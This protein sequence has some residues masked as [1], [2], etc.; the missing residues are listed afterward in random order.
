M[1]ADGEASLPFVRDNHF[2]TYQVSESSTRNNRAF[3]PGT[4]Q[5]SDD[6]VSRTGRG[7]DT[8]ARSDLDHGVRGE[9]QGLQTGLHKS[10]V[11]NVRPAQGHPPRTSSLARSRAPAEPNGLPPSPHPPQPRPAG[12]PNTQT[13]STSTVTLSNLDN[14]TGSNRTIDHYE[15]CQRNFKEQFRIQKESFEAQLRSQ[16][17]GH[18][19]RQQVQAD[20]YENRLQEALD[21]R[22]QF[23][24]A[25]DDAERQ[26]R[27][28]IDENQRLKDENI[29]LR[30]K[31]SELESQAQ[32]DNEKYSAELAAS[33]ASV[34]TLKD[35]ERNVDQLEERLRLVE[36][37][38]SVQRESSH[39]LASKLKE[40]NNQLLARSEAC[41]HLE[42]E[43][44]GYKAQTKR[45][46]HLWQNST[47]ELQNSILEFE[48]EMWNLHQRI[49]FLDRYIATFHLHQRLEDQNVQRKYLQQD[50]ELGRLQRMLRVNVRSEIE[51]IRRRGSGLRE[52]IEA[53]ERSRNELQD[54]QEGSEDDD[55]TF[56]DRLE[57]LHA[58]LERLYAEEE[59]VYAKTKQLQTQDQK[60]SS[61]ITRL[62]K[63]A[64]KYIKQIQ[65]PGGTTLTEFEISKKNLRR[66]HCASSAALHQSKS[67]LPELIQYNDIDADELSECHTPDDLGQLYTF[68]GDVGRN[69]VASHLSKKQKRNSSYHSPPKGFF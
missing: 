33:E 66:L 59:Q 30:G 68:H 40:A 32:Q 23:R 17:D 52:S 20:S 14:G 63:N 38:V 15:P 57:K 4:T 51:V 11:D 35:K 27:Y 46:E 6:N 44:Q 29:R 54:Q 24:D 43:R 42:M 12:D 67:S 50:Q 53:T 37:E 65:Q 36:Q 56:F 10:S 39:D 41:N 26:A 7:R 61:D 28:D 60:I 58:D 69:S 64:R 48:E 21:Q 22:D 2:N 55:E 45:Y 9:K 8:Q 13:P 16:A 25:V 3:G 49:A 5:A 34:D 18:E 62:D 47:T 31:I 19:K 1:S